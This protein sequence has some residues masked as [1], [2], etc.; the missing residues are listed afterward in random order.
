MNN[1]YP[2]CRCV[3]YPSVWR[4]R[5]TGFSLHDL[6]ITSAVAGVLTVSAI[7]MAGLVQDGRMTTK[8]NQLM[9]DLSLARSE[10]IKRNSNIVLCKS[11]DGKSCSK[12]EAWN[13]GWIVFTDNN[14][15]H[16]VDADETIIRVQQALDEKLNLRY[17]E[18]GT[19]Y[20]VRYNPS[21]EAWPGATFSFCDNRG[22]EKAKA[23]IVYW[24]GRPRVS[25][26]TSEG[27]PLSCS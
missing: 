15:N 21:G 18:T 9:A 10:A 7:G 12:A 20:Y 2:G 19:Y 13:N 14:N 23:I 22:A 8:V 5:Q 25:I 16:V 3:A 4:C 27:S 24:S 1:P 11:A 6:I 17:G 26:K